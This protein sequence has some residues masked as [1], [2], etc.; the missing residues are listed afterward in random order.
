MNG[1][2]NHSSL[3]TP[4]FWSGEDLDLS[5]FGLDDSYTLVLVDSGA[6]EHVCPMNFGTGLEEEN[7]RKIIG[8]GGQTI[9]HYGRRE[10]EL[11][12]VDGE[13]AKAIFEV[14]AVRRPI[15]SVGSLNTKGIAVNFDLDDP[16]L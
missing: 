13:R 4:I 3:E 7:R 12:L 1:N 10:V 5:N 16:H 8:A 14:C 11:S 15:L 6:F 9:A 2:G